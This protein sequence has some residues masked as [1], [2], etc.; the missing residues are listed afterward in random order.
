L[1]VNLKV[2]NSY[3]YK[4]IQSVVDS[5]AATIVSIAK[6][7]YDDPFVKMLITDHGLRSIHHVDDICLSGGVADCLA[8]AEGDE[9]KYGDIGIF[10]GRSLN[11][12]LKRAS[13]K[14]LIP[15]ETIRATVIG[16]GMH[17][18]SISGST[19]NFDHKVLPLKN[20]SV[21]RLAHEEEALLG[22]T[23]IEAIRRRVDWSMHSGEVPLVALSLR[24]SRRL[25]FDELQALA[26]DIVQGMV[27]VINLDQPL[28][29]VVD[30]DI[31][32]SLG[33]SIRD[34]LPPRKSVVCIDSV[35]V[36]NGDYIDIGLP[37][38]GGQVLP[39]IVKTLL[40]GD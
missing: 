12:A 25:R 29:V 38:V 34:R 22:H 17:S 6:G 3:E 37:V 20:I 32:K 31:G 10:L 36:D 7:L 11:E 19:I 9:L 23:R 13:F 35:A 33:L 2:N 16:A 18:T 27:R 5:M 26:H 14:L 1:R 30:N 15:K 4:S 21:I 39:V 8:E 40:L 24:G 28:V